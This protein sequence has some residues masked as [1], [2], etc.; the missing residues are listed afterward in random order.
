MLCICS[1]ILNKLINSILLAICTTQVKK[2]VKKKKKKK[3]TKGLLHGDSHPDPPNTL[4]PKAN[5]TIYWTTSVSTHK[6]SITDVYIPSLWWLTVFK[7][8]FFGFRVELNILL[9]EA[10]RKAHSKPINILSGLVRAE[11]R[12]GNLWTIDLAAT[13]WTVW[14]WP[15]NFLPAPKVSFHRSGKTLTQHC[16]SLFPLF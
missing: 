8:F 2:R 12:L 11:K 10:R 15:Y 1:D 16:L 5:A 13:D 9:I 7:D 4:E 14:S 6:S 3:V